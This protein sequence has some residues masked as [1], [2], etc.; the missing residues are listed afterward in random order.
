MAAVAPTEAD[1]WVVVRGRATYR[2]FRLVLDALARQPQYRA[3]VG[4]VAWA[5]L[6]LGA[7]LV[8]RWRVRST[9]LFLVSI[10]RDGAVFGSITLTR[11]GQLANLVVLGSAAERKLVL[12]QV[13]AEIDRLLAGGPRRYFV[14]TFETNRSIRAALARRG[15]DTHAEVRYVVTV[16]LGPLTF[17][18]L[19]HRR[20]ALPFLESRRLLRLERPACGG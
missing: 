5:L 17:S 13:C 7:P 8:Y 3:T 20:P 16:P 12:R 4:T 6:R 1:G 18:W 19:Q 9:H 14:R 2:R 10:E 15:F 11:S